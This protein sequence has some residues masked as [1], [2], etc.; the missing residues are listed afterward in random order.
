MEKAPNNESASEK[1]SSIAEKLK[2]MIG[3][4]CKID[5]NENG[6]MTIG[7]VGHDSNNRFDNYDFYVSTFPDDKILF[8]F[9]TVKKS[10]EDT[11]CLF[12]SNVSA[13]EIIDE[14]LQF[15]KTGIKPVH[16]TFYDI[17]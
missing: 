13:Q 3:G 12:P 9:H 8:S 11:Q 5:D 17:S 2:T 15:D 14:M 10:H 6:S 1:V 16:G 4:D 7:L